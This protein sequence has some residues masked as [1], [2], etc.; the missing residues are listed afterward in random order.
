MRLGCPRASNMRPCA[1]QAR[2]QPEKPK[3]AGDNPHLH[4]HAIEEHA[5]AANVHDTLRSAGGRNA[6]F[7]VG[8]R[9]RGWARPEWGMGWIAARRLGAIRS[10]PW[11]L[12]SW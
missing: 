10:F 1:R 4:L 6:L 2:P 8:L 12:R 11:P 5:A 7:N 3:T 9:S